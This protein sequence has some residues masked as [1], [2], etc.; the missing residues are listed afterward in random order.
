MLLI[1]P[2]GAKDLL[3]NLE[4][5]ATTMVLCAAAIISEAIKAS[6]G[7]FVVSP[8]FSVIPSTPIT[9]EEA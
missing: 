5:S 8:S 1:G 3:P 9:A 2:M 7:V 6:S 4:E